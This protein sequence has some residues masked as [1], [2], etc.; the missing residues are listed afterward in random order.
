MASL[1][2]QKL[3]RSGSNGAALRHKRGTVTYRYVGIDMEQRRRHIEALAN[4]LSS[5]AQTF[6]REVGT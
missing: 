5:D 3:R 2:W 6:S 4:L 1:E